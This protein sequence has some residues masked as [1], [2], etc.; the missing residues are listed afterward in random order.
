MKE[1]TQEIKLNRTVPVHVCQKS[2]WCTVQDGN[3]TDDP[4]PTL[5]FS[6][7]IKCTT[8]RPW[9]LQRNHFTGATDRS[10]TNLSHSHLSRII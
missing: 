6:P 7:C 5:S 2:L 8:C 1:Q 9:E 4:L 3:I 10:L